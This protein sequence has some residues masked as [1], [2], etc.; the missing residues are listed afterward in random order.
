MINKTDYDIEAR[1]LNALLEAICLLA[2]TMDAD[3]PR[4]FNVCLN[5]AFRV[6][7]QNPELQ[8]QVILGMTKMLNAIKNE[9]CLIC[10]M[11]LGDPDHKD[12]DQFTWA[13]SDGIRS[14]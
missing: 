10:H 14:N 4:L 12:H 11:K 9:T 5:I 2:D 1:K 6:A 7:M 13:T 3:T 8:P